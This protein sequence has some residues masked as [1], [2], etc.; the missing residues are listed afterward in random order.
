MESNR[1]A[2][3]Q[4]LQ[5][6]MGALKQGDV[7]KAKRMTAKSLRLFETEKAK[8]FLEQ[9]ADIKEPTQSSPEPKAENVR[10]RA[11][12]KEDV[13]KE[14]TQDQVDAVNKIMKNKNDYYKVLGLEKGASQAE[15]KKGYRKAALK[16][17]P[18]KNTAPRADEAFKIVNKAF[19]VLQ[20]DDKRAHYERYGAEG[21]SISNRPSHHRGGYH[22]FDEDDM[23][24][25]D[26][27]NMFFGGMPTGHRMRRNHH[28]RTFHFG[29]NHHQ[30]QRGEQTMNN[31]NVWLQFM[32]LLI[33]IGLSLISNLMTPDPLYTLSRQGQRGYTKLIYTEKDR[34][35]YYVQPERFDA[36]F[37]KG[38]KE[39]AKV[40]RQVKQD[41]IEVLRNNC[42]QETLNGR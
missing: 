24:A 13:Q 28:H 17:H 36:D 30:H 22:H 27:F 21:P 31:V 16:L 40:E 42:Y 3:E 4:C 15:I 35:S 2:A 20:D 12:P 32:P 25:E 37:P 7:E 10:Q 23:S 26:I 41:Y 39:R 29:G 18:D 11:K 1:E 6:A 9:L 8:I 38:S 14:Y 5:K 33:L 34:I 19:S